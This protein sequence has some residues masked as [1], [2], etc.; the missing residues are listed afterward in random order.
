MPSIKIITSDSLA[1]WLSSFGASGSKLVLTFGRFE[2]LHIGHIR[3]M[4]QA[5]EMGTA[6]AVVPLPR[7]SVPESLQAETLTHLDCV[8]AVLLGVEPGEAL[9][10]IHPAVC[11]V[12]GGEDGNSDD[13]K[14]VEMCARLGIPV[15]STFNIDFGSTLSINRF[16]TGLGE[17]VHE[18]LNLFRAH[19]SR[20]QVEGIIEAMARLKV[21]VIGDTILDEYC[22]CDTLGVSSKDPI[23]A[24]RYRAS[25]L[26]AGG[27]VAVANHVSNFAGEVRL[28]TVLGELDSRREFIESQLNPG[29]LPHFAMQESAPTVRKRRYLEGYTQNKLLEIYYMEDVGLSAERDKRFREVVA[30]TMPDC[31]LII[32]A[33]FGHGAVSPAMRRLLER[34]A[35]YLAVNVQA[36]SGNRGF[37][38]ISKF[39]RADYVSIAEHELRLEMRDMRGPVDQMIDTLAPRLKCPRFAVTRGKRGSTIRCEDG[40]HITVP[41][42]AGKIVDRIGAG[43]AFLSVTA[44]AAKL[45]APPELVCFIGNVVGAL[46]VGILGNQKSIDKQNVRRYVASL[47]G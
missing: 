21:A 6:L 36:N 37:H 26:F 40:R 4:R 2:A 47:L 9:Q 14:I 5:R 11:A 30:A 3:H 43:D 19:Y 39:S 35:P 13:G 27:I 10:R 1:D 7:S 24:L 29:I 12:S 41:A 44:L 33:D 25:D 22:Y 16:L 15:K 32:A 20:E 45:A 17:D 18:Y 28:F 42:F 8:D 31:D 34:N 46:A 38:T 23:L